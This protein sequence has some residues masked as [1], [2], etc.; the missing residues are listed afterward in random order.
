MNKEIANR[1]CAN[2]LALKLSQNIQCDQPDRVSIDGAIARRVVELHPEHNPALT[3]C[4]PNTFSD[5][6]FEKTYG[7]HVWDIVLPA[8]VKIM[9][10]TDSCSLFED[11][12]VDYG[13]I[14]AAVKRRCISKLALLLFQHLGSDHTGKDRN[15]FDW[16]RAEEEVSKDQYVVS[17]VL[18]HGSIYALYNFDLFEMRHG[19]LVWDRLYV[20]LIQPK[21][22]ITL[23][24]GYTTLRRCQT[25]PLGC[26]CPASKVVKF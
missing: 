22:L 16:R 1:L 21:D 17:N 5:A 19:N 13:I 4:W 2:N 3:S 26:T 12:H 11:G 8:C 23:P 9:T 7:K 6:D 25:H 10:Q 15:E 18:K 14:R 24:P 20:P